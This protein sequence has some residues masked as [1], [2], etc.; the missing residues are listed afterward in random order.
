MGYFKNVSYSTKIN[1]GCH[2][3]LNAMYLNA[4]PYIREN[5]FKDSDKKGNLVSNRFYL[6]MDI[7]GLNIGLD[8]IEIQ[9]CCEAMLERKHIEATEKQGEIA[10]KIKFTKA[11]VR[12]YKTDFYLREI[13]KANLFLN[14]QRSTVVNNILTPFLALTAITIS[15]FSYINERYPDK[16]LRQILL[17]LKASQQLTDSATRAQLSAI[18]HLLSNSQKVGEK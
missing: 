4:K 6:S 16:Q 9:D 12:A 3:I 5:K 7:T 13:R 15:Y 8:D 18:N 11:G 2:E 17:E 1:K 14:I 10:T